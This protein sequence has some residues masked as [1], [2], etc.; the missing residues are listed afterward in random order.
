M[1]CTNGSFFGTKLFYT[2]IRARAPSAA[3]TWLVRACGGCLGERWR[4][5][6]KADRHLHGHEN[7]L[8]HGGAGRVLPQVLRR[9]VN[10]LRQD[11]LLAIDPNVDTS[12][13]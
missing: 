12:P 6:G 2:K 8:A 9:R 1:D 4:V 7:R 3:C 5:D 13:L 11:A 10:V